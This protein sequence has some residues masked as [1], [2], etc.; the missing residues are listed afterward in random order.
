MHFR[1]GKG[2]WWDPGASKV[3]WL[4]VPWMVNAERQQIDSVK[5]EGW[6][7]SDPGA[8]WGPVQAARPLDVLSGW[9]QRSQP[10]QIIVQALP[11]GLFNDPTKKGTPAQGAGSMDS[12]PHWGGLDFNKSPKTPRTDCQK[13]CFLVSTAYFYLEFG[14]SLRLPLMLLLVTVDPFSFL[15]KT[16]GC[17][18]KEILSRGEKNH[19]CPHMS[20]AVGTGNQRGDGSCF[21][22][23]TDFKNMWTPPPISTA[24]AVPEYRGGLLTVQNSE[25]QYLVGKYLAIFG[26]FMGKFFWVFVVFFGPK[27]RNFLSRK[28]YT[29]YKKR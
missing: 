18:F 6:K 25:E 7:F 15:K 19:L 11:F 29:S 13:W 24:W 1:S 16:L 17:H 10:A 26:K 2:S 23:S 21:A 8:R 20:R 9:C 4:V 22:G 5:S 3:R 27:R 28:S 14:K 12:T